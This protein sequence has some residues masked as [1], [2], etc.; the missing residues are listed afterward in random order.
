MTTGTP[1]NGTPANGTAANGT[2]GPGPGGHLSAFDLVRAE[3]GARALAGWAVEQLTTAAQRGPG[4]VE[5][6][7]HPADLVTPVDRA[8]E[9]HVRSVLAE[10]FPA[11]AVLGE[12]T[13]GPAD[14][15]GRPLWLVDPVDGTTNFAHGIAWSSFALA[16]LDGDGTPQVGVVAD[17]WRGETFTAVR[18]HGARC[19]DAPV[20]SGDAR[21]LAGHVVLTEWSAHRPWPGMNE[22]LAALADRYCTSRIMGSSALS[23]VQVAAG[24][25]AGAVL[26][27]DDPLDTAAG[28]LIATEAGAA[29]S[30]H[31]A[32]R[33]RDPSGTVTLL[34]AAVPALAGELRHLAAST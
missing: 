16:L 33:D 3:G 24:R 15:G 34:V 31:R 22:F 2:A 13:G 5:A 20:T 23:L 14:A 30:T 1:A 9:A 29:V 21:T 10:Q 12:E 26:G 19:N 18:G 28:R 32:S 6:K 8:V 25:A 7:D 4:P 11:H 27:S 17:P